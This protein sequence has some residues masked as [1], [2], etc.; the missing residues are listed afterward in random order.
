MTLDSC[1]SWNKVLTSF[2]LSYP[3]NYK[4][5]YNDTKESFVTLTYADSVGSVIQEI[6]IGRNENLRTKEEVREWT[7]KID[8]ALNSATGFKHGT[9]MNENFADKEYFILRGSFDFSSYNSKEFD[10]QYDFVAFIAPPFNTD[11]NGVSYSIITKQDNKNS[12]LRNQA[13]N[14]LRT[15]V[16]K[17]D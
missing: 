12:D 15:L 6:S 14:I 3:T 16:F 10:G 17:N 5:K 4:I 1:K 11:Y 9:I 13:E 7:L 8:S 2:E